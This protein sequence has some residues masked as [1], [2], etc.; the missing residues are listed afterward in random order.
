MPH[1]DAR[2][3]LCPMP[4][5]RVSERVRALAPGEVLTVACTD[6]GA[7]YD[8]PVWCRL[9]GHEVLESRVEP[10]GE[11]SIVIRVRP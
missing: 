9:E 11:V 3:L 10:T 8:I 1:L 7:L 5:I 6:R 2:H 4:V